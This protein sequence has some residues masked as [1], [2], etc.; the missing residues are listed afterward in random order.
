MG[1][2]ITAPD[3]ILVSASEGED[4]TGT[5]KTVALY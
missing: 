4:W 5:P 3:R 1:R 2:S